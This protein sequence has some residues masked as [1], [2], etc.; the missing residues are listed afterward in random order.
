MSRASKNIKT[1]VGR[2]VVLVYQPRP[3]CCLVLTE[4]HRGQCLFGNRQHR[5]KSLGI[6]GVLN[7]YMGTYLNLFK[8]ILRKTINATPSGVFTVISTRAFT[9]TRTKRLLIVIVRYNVMWL[10]NNILHY[11]KTSCQP[12]YCYPSAHIFV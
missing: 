7:T 8:L 11:N 4:G 6:A 5:V 3:L 1:I 9:F 2:T 10:H 12:C